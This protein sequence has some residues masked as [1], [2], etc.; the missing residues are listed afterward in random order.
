MTRPFGALEWSVALRYL[1]LRGKESFISVIA[2]FS[3]LGITLGVAT[4]VIVMSVM[5]GFH[6]ELLKRFLG[7]GGHINLRPQVGEFFKNYEGLAGQIRE[8]EGIERAFPTIRG[9]L[10]LSGTEK[11]VGALVNGIRAEDLREV[12]IVTENLVSGSVSALGIADVV[13]GEQLARELKLHVGDTV[14]LI[15]PNGATTPFGTIPRLRTH[16]VV[17]IF[18]TGLSQVDSHFIY[19]SLEAAQEFFD[20]GIKIIEIFVQDPDEVE[21]FLEPLG[22]LRGV[23]II[24]WQH[25][26]TSLFRALQTERSVMLIILTLIIL[27]AAFNTISG[28]IMLVRDKRR[29]IAILRVM[30]M[31]RRGILRIFFIT[32]SSIGLVG[33]AIGLCLGSVIASYVEEINQWLS[34]WLGLKIFPSDAYFVSEIPSRVDF[35]DLVLI[36][37][38]SLGLAFLSTLYPSWRAASLEPAEALRYE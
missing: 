37:C 17:A 11:S 8:I 33:T 30:G 20:S 38:L 10:L 23:K 7:V 25:M 32:G 2:G 9:Q 22:G 12:S 29:D 13:V 27:V 26:H 28:L 34:R 21:E 16:R 14:T 1:R 35:G 3:F 4:L 19:I 6:E 15:S 31:S 5:N 24:T 36:T 18:R